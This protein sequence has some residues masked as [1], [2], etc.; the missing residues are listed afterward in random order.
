MHHSLPHPTGISRCRKHLDP[1]E[2]QLQSCCWDILM[3]NRKREPW[4]SGE[5]GRNRRAEESPWCSFQQGNV[6]QISFGYLPTEKTVV[7]PG[8]ILLL[9]SLERPWRCSG[10][11]FLRLQ[12]MQGAC[13]EPR[14]TVWWCGGPPSWLLLWGQRLQQKDMT[15][16]VTSGTCPNPGAAPLQQALGA[17]APGGTSAGDRNEE[18]LFHLTVG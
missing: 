9:P 1:Q 2:L 16:C 6:W 4:A 17:A 3:R 5:G 11:L 7:S 18:G 14:C 12:W 15:G 10:C 8:C 13:V